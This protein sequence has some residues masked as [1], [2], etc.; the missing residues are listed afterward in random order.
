V[1]ETSENDKIMLKQLKQPAFITQRSE[2][3][4]HWLYSGGS[5]K[6][7][8]YFVS[9]ELRMQKL[10]KTELMQMLGIT[11]VGS[12]ALGE[13]R[14]HFVARVLLQLAPVE[15]CTRMGKTGIPWVPWASHGNEN[16]ISDGMGMGTSSSAIAER[17][18]CRV[19]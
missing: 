12:Q 13:V 10:S 14:Y 4:L 6:I 17:P 1:I 7:L 16:K 5:E 11:T 9:D 15:M 19:G 2:R 8:Q 18:R 3:C